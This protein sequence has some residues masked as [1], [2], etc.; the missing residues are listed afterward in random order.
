MAGL[1]EAQEHRRHAEAQEGE[2]PARRGV[3]AGREHGRFTGISQS[4]EH[5]SAADL[6]QE[7]HT[8]EHSED[9]DD[10]EVRQEVNEMVKS[11]RAE[12]RAAAVAVRKAEQAVRHEKRMAEERDKRW[13]AAEQ[14]DEPPPAYLQ[15]ERA[16]K[17]QVKMLKARLALSEARREAAEAD[18]RLNECLFMREE[19]AHALTRCKLIS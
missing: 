5:S 2:G 12:V 6:E 16:Y 8:Q 15:L 14:R 9:D 3:E 19:L 11:A 17:G 10:K 4:E 7:E 13:W 1:W 18:A